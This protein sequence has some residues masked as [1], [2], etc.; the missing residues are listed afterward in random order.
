MRGDDRQRELAG[1][2]RGRGDERVVVGMAGA[3]D[4]EGVAIREQGR[5]PPRR[6]RRSG[7]V[8]LGQRLADL[9]VARSR[10]RDE[11]IGAFGEPRAR[12]LRV[13]AVLVAAVGARE[14]LGELQIALARLGEQQHPERLVALGIVRHPHI[15]ADD[16]LDAL[17]ARGAVELD[18]PEHVAEIGHRQRRHGV[19]RCRRHGVVDAQRAVGD[20]VL[21]VQP[22]M[23][24]TRCAHW[25][26]F[27]LGTPV[28]ALRTARRAHG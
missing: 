20:R 14:P 21:A 27:V 23:D 10:Q 25:M 24:E 16:R 17:G 5:P 15:A 7:G 28:F 9:A 26:T 18:E 11:A 4:L 1:E 13:P 3:L 2:P 19:R 12:E 8:A 6:L 22:Q